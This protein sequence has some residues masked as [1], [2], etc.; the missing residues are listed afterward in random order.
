[1]I[2]AFTPTPPQ[3]SLFLAYV[4]FYSY[5]SSSMNL[6]NR[7]PF[8]AQQF[9]ITLF[10]SDTSTKAVTVEIIIKTYLLS[11]MRKNKFKSFCIFMSEPQ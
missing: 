7:W 10:D 8:Q 9:R 1:M 5:N 2:Q 4:N 11:L 3:I 6:C